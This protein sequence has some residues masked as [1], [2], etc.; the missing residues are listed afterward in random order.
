MPSI[1]RSLVI[2]KKGVAAPYQQFDKAMSHGRLVLIVTLLLSFT[3]PAF[4]HE[5]QLQ[6][7]DN[8]SIVSTH[9]WHLL[10]LETDRYEDYYA[11]DEPDDDKNC[12][13]PLSHNESC[14]YVTMNCSDDIQFFNYLELLA[15]ALPNAQVREF[16]YNIC[17][18][19]N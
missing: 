10:S 7:R 12:T 1:D 2:K 8:L 13:D 11:V 15:C 6:S 19:F 4:G 18:N 3:S 16:I 9:H 17:V 5:S 14:L